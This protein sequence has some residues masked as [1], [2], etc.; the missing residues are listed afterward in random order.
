MA[1]I[2]V[3]YDDEPSTPPPKG[4]AVKSELRLAVEGIKVGYSATFPL[5]HREELDRV[6]QRIRQAE[7]GS[8]LAV[9]KF[10]D[11]VRVWR[12]A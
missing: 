4:R 7:P 9:R 8:K 12:I 10:K 1:D 6:A 11:C 5:N 3:Q 2:Q